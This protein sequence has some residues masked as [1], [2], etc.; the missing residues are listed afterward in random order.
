MAKDN[1]WFVGFAPR[2]NPEIVVVTLSEASGWGA[3]AAPI[4]RDVIKSYF[5]KKARLAQPATLRA[6]QP[7]LFER[8]Q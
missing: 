5:D 2:D 3:N 6:Q 7:T 8:P 4:V 1:G